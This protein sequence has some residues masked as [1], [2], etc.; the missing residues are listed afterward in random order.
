MSHPLQA[1]PQHKRSP[2]MVKQL[3]LAQCHRYHHRRTS[4]PLP[5][6]QLIWPLPRYWLPLTLSYHHHSILPLPCQSTLSPPLPCCCP[7][8]PPLPHQPY[9]DP[10]PAPKP[11]LCPPAPC[12][13]T[14]PQLPPLRKSEPSRLPW[15]LFNPSPILRPTP[16]WLRPPPS[17][18]LQRATLCQQCPVSCLI[19]SGQVSMW[20]LGRYY[21][22]LIT[23]RKSSQCA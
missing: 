17:F 13:L 18:W 11:Q 19:R 21:I 20:I 2:P 22:T 1:R 6:R 3:A 9:W 23:R 16:P 14:S 8:P 10:L 4:T 7:S 15:R 5:C 12:P